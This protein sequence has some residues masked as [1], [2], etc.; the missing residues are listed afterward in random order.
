MPDV[1]S[2]LVPV[3]RVDEDDVGR[4][5]RSAVEAPLEVRLHGEPFAVIMRTPGAD[6][7]LTAG[8]LFTEGVLRSNADLAR[9]DLSTEHRRRPF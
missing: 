5:D 3:R 7:D 1:T 6:R 2:R 4:D 8:F 9:V